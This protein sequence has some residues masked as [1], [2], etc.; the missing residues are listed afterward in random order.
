MGTFGEY[1]DAREHNRSTF[2]ETVRPAFE[3]SIRAFD[4]LAL[5]LRDGRDRNDKTAASLAPF[6]FILQRQALAAYDALSTNQAYLA[7][8]LIRPGVESALIIGKWVDDE[9]HARIWEKR[10]TNMKAY[11][12]VY[13]GKALRSKSLPRSD[14]IQLSLSGINDRFLHPNPEYYFRH[15]ELNELAGGAVEMKLNVFDEPTDVAVGVLGVLHLVVVIQD[16]LARLFA[17]TFPNLSRIDVGLTS[18]ETG[19]G[20]W[21]GSVMRESI[22]A[23]D[24]LRVLGLWPESYA[25]AEGL[26]HQIDSAGSAPTSG[27]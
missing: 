9:I 15:L 12:K 14:E 21:A 6:F 13:E 7:W 26:H 23:H 5:Q 24:A 4:Q 3:I 10:R 1:L 8:V 11:R 2:P 17:N 22:Q 27:A 16:C 19:M 25:E 18:L 20:E